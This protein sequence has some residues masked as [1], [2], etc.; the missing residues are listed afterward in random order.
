MCDE[1]F[2]DDLQLKLENPT[3]YYL[4][5]I[6]DIEI[7]DALKWE[8]PYLYED[9]IRLHFIQEMM[10]HDNINMCPQC[11]DNIITDEWGEE[12]CECCGLVTRTHY[13]YVAGQRIV[14][15]YGLK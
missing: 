14:L 2:S 15:D 9:V 5:N 3:K 10:N 8:D 4:Q 7:M 11:R 12:Y 6:N 13:P 1:N